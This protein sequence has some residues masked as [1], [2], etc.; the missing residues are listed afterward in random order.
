MRI[1]RT[2]ASA[3]QCCSA[4][5]SPKPYVVIQTPAFQGILKVMAVSVSNSMSYILQLQ[6][7]QDNVDEV[8]A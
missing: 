2:E 3:H 1:K 5:Y 8:P 7:G 6:R 4:G